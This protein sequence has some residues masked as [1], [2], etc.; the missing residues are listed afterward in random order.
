MDPWG[1][2]PSSADMETGQLISG[3]AHV[4]GAALDRS[5]RGAADVVRALNGDLPIADV[6]GGQHYLDWIT[7]GTSVA[8]APA[9]PTPAMREAVSARLGT[10]GMQG[11]RGYKDDDGRTDKAAMLRHMRDRLTRTTSTDPIQVALDREPLNHDAFIERVKQS[12]T[13]SAAL[14]R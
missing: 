5:A 8:D 2:G 3:N 4:Y 7:R 14:T 6:L 9:S 10:A 13:L 11:Y 1:A 12:P